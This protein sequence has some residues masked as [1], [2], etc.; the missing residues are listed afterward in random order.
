M[1]VVPGSACR[2]C[3]CCSCSEQHNFVHLIVPLC[4]HLLSLP[5]CLPYLCLCSESCLLIWHQ[6]SSFSFVSCF[7]LS[8][9]QIIRKNNANQKWNKPYRLWF[10]MRR[11]EIP[12]PALSQ[13]SGGTLCKLLFLTLNWF[14]LR[15]W[16]TALCNEYSLLTMIVMGALSCN[17]GIFWSGTWFIYLL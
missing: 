16:A 5:K 13:A 8:A 14:T 6:V 17:S 7:S 11:S 1:T 9:C 3:M 15:Q 10:R 12:F 2:C 4:L